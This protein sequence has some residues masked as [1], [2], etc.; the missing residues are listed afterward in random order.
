MYQV[1]D[2][3]LAIDTWASLHPF[4]EQ[5]FHQALAKVVWSKNFCPDDMAEH[6]RRIKDVPEGDYKSP[7]AYA[8]EVYRGAAWGVVDFIKYNRLSAMVPG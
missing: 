8:I 3:F 4:D 6:F 7:V 1:F 5:R 2:S